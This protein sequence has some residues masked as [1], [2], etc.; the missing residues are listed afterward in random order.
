[1]SREQ[2]A[3]LALRHVEA[4]RDGDVPTLMADYAEDAKIITSG[5]VVDGYAAIE[6]M[7]STNLASDFFSPT[8][9][10]TTFDPPVVVDDEVAVVYWKTVNE[11]HRI[12]GGIDTLV[13][14]DG[15]IALHTASGEPVPL[16]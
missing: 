13:V 14:R 10:K 8:K 1:M 9:S 3:K 4:F 5:G 6:A 2:L 16:D 15:K 12:A 7:F 11:T